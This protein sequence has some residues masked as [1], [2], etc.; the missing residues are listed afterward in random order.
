MSFFLVLTVTRHPLTH[1]Q[2]HAFSLHILAK[3]Y[4]PIRA[5]NHHFMM[6]VN[7]VRK[8]INLSSLFLIWFCSI[9]WCLRSHKLYLFHSWS[10]HVSFVEGEVVGISFELLLV[11]K[12]KNKETW[13]ENLRCCCL[14]MHSISCWV[15]IS[16]LRWVLRI[17]NHSIVVEA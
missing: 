10:L 1:L 12:F 3:F 8:R 5:S 14:A 9:L 7:K 16:N 6:L 15:S 13:L 2:F 4:F 11:K 17:F